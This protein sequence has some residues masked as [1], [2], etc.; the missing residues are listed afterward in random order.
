MMKM[1]SKYD[2]MNRNEIFYTF[3]CIHNH[4]STIITYNMIE[5]W[6]SISDLRTTN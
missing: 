4:L 2:N 3:I 1:H 5:S 6:Y